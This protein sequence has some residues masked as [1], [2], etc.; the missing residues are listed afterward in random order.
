MTLKD[1]ESQEEM[2]LFHPA[3]KTAR[4]RFSRKEKELVYSKKRTPVTL[5]AAEP[6]FKQFFRQDSTYLQGYINGYD[7]RL[8]L[9]PVLFICQMN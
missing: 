2:T 5:V 8:D 6:D 1:R 9:T 7:P 3:K 4:V